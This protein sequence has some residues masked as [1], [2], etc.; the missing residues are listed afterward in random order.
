MNGE[1]NRSV[2][3]VWMPTVVILKRVDDNGVY[4]LLPYR[5]RS[6]MAFARL[7]DTKNRRSDWYLQL[8][9][10]LLLS[11]EKSPNIRRIAEKKYFQQME[12]KVFCSL[13]V[14]TLCTRRLLINW[15]S[16]AIKKAPVMSREYY[17]NEMLWK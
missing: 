17:A 1:V 4:V 9:Q 6:I 14:G 16:V 13:F 2:N 8:Q 3:G 7:D 11:K 15:L 12:E 5:A 10:Y